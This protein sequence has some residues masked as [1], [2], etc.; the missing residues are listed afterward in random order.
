MGLRHNMDKESW[1][2]LEKNSTFLHL[3]ATRASLIHMYGIQP[4]QKLTR[5]EILHVYMKR[6]GLTT[7]AL[8]QGLGL[9]CEVIKAALQP[10]SDTSDF[11]LEILEEL[12]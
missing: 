4:E 10:N 2:R 8:W 7:L 11:L 6:Y 5:Y 12:P 9:P 1:S 3:P